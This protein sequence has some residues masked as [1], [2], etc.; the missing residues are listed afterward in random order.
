[1]ALALATSSCV[2][3][4]Q[5][6]STVPSADYD[7]FVTNVQPVLAD[8]CGQRSCHGTIDRPLWVYAPGGLRMDTNAGPLHPAE[9]ESNYWSARSFLVDVDDP[10]A[11]LLLSKPLDVSQG[12]VEHANGPVFADRREHGYVALRQW[13]Q[14]AL[15][16]NQ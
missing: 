15:E 5:L 10:D 6:G 4:P 13:L 2:D 3:G 7:A 11:S 14:L 8:R 9:L 1:M 12:G 16:D